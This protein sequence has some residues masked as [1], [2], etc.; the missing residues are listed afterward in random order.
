MALV[1]SVTSAGEAK[2]NW[3]QW[4]GPAMNGVAVGKGY[5]VKWS[6]EENVVWKYKLPGIGASTPAVWDDK[7][8][9][10]GESGG[11]N[12]VLCLNRAGKKLWETKLDK[13]RPAKNRGA[14]GSNPSPTTDGKHIFAYYKSGTLTCL[15]MAGESVW[16]KNIQK[17][18]GADTLWWDLGTSPVLTK[19]HVVVA[20]MQTGGSYL[21]AFD[22][23]TGEVAWKQARELNAPGESAQSYTTPLVISNGDKELLIVLGADH[24]T[25]HDAATGKQIWVAGDLNPSGARNWRSISSPVISDGF[26]IAP[27]ARGR[28]LTAIRLG[29]KGDVTKSHVVWEEGP[30]A[31][32]PTPVAAHGKVFVCTDRGSVMVKD[33]KTGKALAQIEIPRSRQSIW[34]SPILA[35]GHLY[36]TNQNGTTYVLKVGSKLELVSENKLED[37]TIATPVFV[38]GRIYIRTDQHLHCIGKK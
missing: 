19:K 33:I 25:A 23:A 26:V 34:S 11:M 10:T 16:Q 30:S 9:L 5:P 32:V 18:Y 6:A 13:E 37:Y 15:D 22:K 29:G 4:R 21:A 17:E 31:D 27:Y 1:L 24:V 28:S 36:V 2:E 7:I 14:S 35:D 38:D 3:P 8:V 12:S 20:V